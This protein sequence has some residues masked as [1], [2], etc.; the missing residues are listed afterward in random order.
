MIDFITYSD[1]EYFLGNSLNMIIGPNGTGKSTLVCGLCLGLL[2]EPGVLGRSKDLSEFIKNGCDKA[3]IE[4]ELQGLPGKAAPVIRRTIERKQSGAHSAWSINGKTVTHKEVEKAV[5][6][7]NIQVD[8][9]CQFLPQDKVASF[10]QSNPKDLLLA[11]ERAIG[12]TDMVEDHKKLIELSKKLTEFNNSVSNEAE[13][14]EALEAEHAEQEEQINSIKDL[15]QQKQ[16]K[17][18]LENTLPYVEYED[19]KTQFRELKSEY[20]NITKEIEQAEQRNLPFQEMEEETKKRAQRLREET[21]KYEKSLKSA[22]IQV[23]NKAKEVNN[24]QSELDD[25]KSER[26]NLSRR[27]AHYDRELKAIRDKR[28][29][30][31]NK[32]ERLKTEKAELLDDEVLQQVTEQ[33]HDY[34]NQLHQ[35]KEEKDSISKKSATLKR[36]KAKTLESK[37]RVEGQIKNMDTAFSKKIS[38]LNRLAQSTNARELV[39]RTKKVLE[40]LEKNKD[41]FS[42]EVLDP[43]VLSLKVKEPS[44]LKQIGGTI[45]WATMWT[46]TCQTPEDHRLF[47]KLVLDQSDLNVRYSSYTGDKTKPSDHTK[48][49]SDQQIRRYGFNG[50]ILDLLDGPDAVLNLLCHEDY[51]HATP[52]VKGKVGSE[53]FERLQELKDQRGKPI[54]Q[55]IVDNDAVRVFSKSNYGHKN[56]TSNRNPLHDSLP[57]HF[58]TGEDLSDENEKKQ[59]M[60]DQLDDLQAK[61]TRLSSQEKQLSEQSAQFQSRFSELQN[62]YHELKERKAAHEDTRKASNSLQQRVKEFASDIVQREN[63]R[64]DFVA[65][66]QELGEIIET[67]TSELVAPIEPLKGLLEQQVELERKIFHTVLEVKTLEA[68][69]K[70]F[71]RLSKEGFE[72]LE[73]KKSDIESQV[74][75]LKANLTQLKQKIREIPEELI[76]SVKAKSAEGGSIED[77]KTELNNVSASIELS[78]NSVGNINRIMEKYNERKEKIENLRER[79]NSNNSEMAELKEQIEAIRGEWEPSLDQLISQVSDR[80][81]NAFSSIGCKGEVRLKKV[82]ENYGEWATEILVSFRENAP[83]Q[84]LTGQRQSGGERSV[85]TVLYLMSLQEFA[86]SPFRVVDEINQGMDTRNERMIHNKMVDVACQS[87]TSQYFLVTPKLLPNLNYDRNMNVSC[88]FSGP[89]VEDFRGRDVGAKNTASKLKQLME[90]DDDATE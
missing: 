39:E 14:L 6:K 69:A 84:L 19:K 73:A 56:I 25:A 11:T 43:P 74:R 85:S 17:T 78:S 1:T 9:L 68:E 44:L 35:M 77:L 45:S 32:L 28:D 4:I 20:E 22:Q 36:D 49:L 48:P 83:L 37:E 82:P 13:R 52:F 80:F 89:M 3:T 63:D 90:D 18:V 16:K 46:F 26:E 57:K 12:S 34:R 2:G 61:L 31:Q 42:K 33:M 23:S 30:T 70:E 66:N 64:P 7:F 88:I 60:Q 41:K 75:E 21:S 86:R 47:G 79:V 15:E 65:K 10:A 55:K 76:E 24:I 59:E 62:K 27:E 54:I 51:V 67:K 58:N 40:L 72:E 38:R 71:Y 87:S 29:Q 50:Y 81:Q 8:N 53:T 5:R